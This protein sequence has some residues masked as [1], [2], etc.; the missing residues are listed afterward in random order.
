MMLKGV[1]DILVKIVIPAERQVVTVFNYHTL[2]AYGGME[3]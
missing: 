3:V 2:K 1:S